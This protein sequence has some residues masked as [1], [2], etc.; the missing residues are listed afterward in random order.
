M[1]KMIGF[2]LFFKQKSGLKDCGNRVLLRECKN[3]IFIINNASSDFTG[4]Y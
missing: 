4:C 1:P 3:E 2:L